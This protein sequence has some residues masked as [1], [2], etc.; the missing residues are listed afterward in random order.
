MP[1]A[2]RTFALCALLL[3]AVAGPA[4]A[5]KARHGV[6][7]PAPAPATAEEG[8]LEGAAIMR[9]AME[10]GYELTPEELAL[11]ELETAATPAPAPGEQSHPHASCSSACLQTSGIQDCSPVD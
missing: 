9:A 10:A 4:A 1:Q 5:R 6:A 3:L 7:A 2:A 8:L 11:L